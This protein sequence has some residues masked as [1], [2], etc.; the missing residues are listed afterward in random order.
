MNT[1]HKGPFHMTTPTSPD[2]LDKIE[3]VLDETDRTRFA[4]LIAAFIAIGA[5]TGAIS[6]AAFGPVWTI[7]GA[8]TS[9]ALLVLASIHVKRNRASY[10]DYTRRDGE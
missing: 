5:I 2:M 9:I 3:S 6:S 7:L 8:L 4:I 1:L 10:N